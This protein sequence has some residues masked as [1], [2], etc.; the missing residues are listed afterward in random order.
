VTESELCDRTF[1]ALQG[2]DVHAAMADLAQGLTECRARL[3]PQEW[4]R[5]EIAVREH[6]VHHLLLH[7]PLTR[8]AFEK[9][10]GYAGDAELIDFIYGCGSRARNLSTLGEE[11]YAFEFDSHACRSVRYRRARLAREIDKAAEDGRLTS[12]L[13]VACGH[14]REAELSVALRNRQVSITALDQDPDS[15]AVVAQEYGSFGVVAY[16]GT[17]LDILRRRVK[18]RDFNLIY[19][20][21]LYDYLGTD[22]AAALTAELFRR[23]APAGRLVIANFTPETHD[24][25]YMEACMNW[26]LIY[27]D[28]RQM[29][30][31][32][33]EVQSPEVACLEQ[34]RDPGG[35][36]TFMAVVR[37]GQN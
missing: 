1:D 27:R 6:Q 21:G 5:C 11:L 36:I 10:R 33:R 32:L 19:A 3:S 31:L 37:R 18:S 20:A 29:E 13:A 7:S 17:V 28:E 25:G 30:A 9:P 12:V 2:D 16:V 8:R 22:I 14:L 35:N 26:H 23:L 24:A 4:S 34:F 15:V